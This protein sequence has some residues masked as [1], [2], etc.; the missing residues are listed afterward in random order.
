MLRL[1]QD[2]TQIL[3]DE[4]VQ[5]AAWNVARCT[6]LALRAASSVAAPLAHVI[7]LP[8]RHHG[9]CGRA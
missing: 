1:G 4:V 9:A 7:G 3:P 8:A 2:G 6:A 5:G